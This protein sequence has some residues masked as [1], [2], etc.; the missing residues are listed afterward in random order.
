MVMIGVPLCL[1]LLGFIIVP[2]GVIGA[3]LSF[4]L[5]KGDKCTHC[6]WTTGAITRGKSANERYQ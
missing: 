2:I 6:G 4:A 3:A 5:L 1:V